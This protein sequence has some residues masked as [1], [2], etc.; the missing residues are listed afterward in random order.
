MV[1][2]EPTRQTARFLRQYFSPGSMPAYTSISQCAWSSR[3]CGRVLRVSGG[4]AGA[5]SQP[6][7][8]GA[9]QHG[10]NAQRCAADPG[11]SQAPRS[12]HARRLGRPGSAVH[13]SAS[14][15]AAPRPGNAKASA[16]SVERVLPVTRIRPHFLRPA[17]RFARSR[18]FR[19]DENMRTV[20]LVDCAVTRAVVRH[21]LFFAAHAERKRLTL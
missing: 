2:N 15:R 7:I 3:C 13:R 21:L 5:A 10:A 4:R 20:D 6:R 12:W 16:Q 11:P 1:V 18:P 8:P 19:A 14:L 17:A 9:A